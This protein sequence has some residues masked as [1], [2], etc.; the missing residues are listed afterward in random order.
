MENIKWNWKG[1]A[2][3]YRGK[4]YNLKNDYSHYDI[5]IETF[6]NN[7]IFIEVKSTKSKFGNKLPLFISRK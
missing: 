6:N 1:Q 7:K 3:E 4:K 5:V 2:F